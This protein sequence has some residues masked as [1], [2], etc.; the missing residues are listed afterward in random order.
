MSM[1]IGERLV[2]GFKVFDHLGQKGFH[3]SGSVRHIVDRRRDVWVHIHR[4]TTQT[5]RP[6]PFA[7]PIMWKVPFE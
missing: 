1:S 6:F 7:S 2:D 5:I 3:A 4:F